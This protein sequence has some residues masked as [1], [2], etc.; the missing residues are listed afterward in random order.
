MANCTCCCGNGKYKAI[1]LFGAPGSGK[2]TQGKVLG[3]LPGFIHT[4]TGDLFRSL[5]KQSEMGQLFMQYS[6]RGELVPDEFTV[7]L[8]IEAMKKLEAAGKLN[9]KSDI[10]VMDGIPRNVKQAELLSDTIEV[11]KIIHLNVADMSK[12]VDRLKKRAIKENRVDDADEAVIRNRMDVY[13]R[14]SKP[15][16][17]FYPQQKIANIE[18][19]QSMLAVL[20]DIAKAVQPVR[21]AIDAAE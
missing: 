1:L 16:L 12:M 7:K 15:I 21:D 17:D 10:L 3:A 4:S 5:D 19:C 14:S 18:A 20:A 9:R 6:S 8:W 13:N 11:V 2:G